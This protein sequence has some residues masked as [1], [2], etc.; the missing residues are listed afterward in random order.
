MS[1]R[2]WIWL[3]RV[4]LPY[5]KQARNLSKPGDA[6][7]TP[8]NKPEGGGRL[9]DRPL[10]EG[11]RVELSDFAEPLLCEPAMNLDEA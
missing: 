1:T 5:R 9:I 6:N 10:P 3:S 7:A 11:I 8:T 4:R 2:L